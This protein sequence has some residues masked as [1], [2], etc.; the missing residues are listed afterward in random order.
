MHLCEFLG[1]TLNTVLNTISYSLHQILIY[2]LE[3]YILFSYSKPKN[4]RKKRGLA[5]YQ[6]C[7]SLM[8]RDDHTTIIYCSWESFYNNLLKI[9]IY[10]F[11]FVLL[12]LSTKLTTTALSL[13]Q[14][15]YHTKIKHNTMG[16]VLSYTKQ[17][18]QVLLEIYTE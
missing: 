4:E 15:H 3:V 18:G 14:H 17:N 2:L 16:K 11:T 13:S 5:H 12:S 8:F 10:K 9:L 1:T 7:N 6:H